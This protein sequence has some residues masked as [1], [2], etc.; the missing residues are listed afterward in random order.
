MMN[1]KQIAWLKDFYSYKRPHGSKTEQDWIHTYIMPVVNKAAATAAPRKV[2]F[3]DEAGNIHLDLRNDVK[4]TT[5]FVAHTDTVHR[6]EGRQKVYTINVGEKQ[7]KQVLYADANNSATTALGADDASGVLMLLHL[8]QNRV[9]AYYIFT[10][11]EECGGIGSSYL[12]D[13][14]ATLLIQFDRAIAFD[15]KG[16]SSVITHQAY[17]RTCSDKFADALS[18]S[19]SNMELMYAPDNTGVYTDTAEF[20]YLI[21]E[22]TNISVGYAQEHTAYE[23]QDLTHLHHLMNTAITIDWDALPTANIPAQEEEY[24]YD[25][26]DYYQPQQPQTKQSIKNYTKQSKNYNDKFNKQR[27]K[28][29]HYGMH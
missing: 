1:A 27:A 10:R 23:W 29:K 19:L 6:T 4:N 24:D 13:W 11:G 22:C 7:S 21:P 26:W 12:A 16:T 17:G 20:V 8:I 25:D 28:T 2:T 18:E 15:R 9:P 5:L 3:V 14:Y